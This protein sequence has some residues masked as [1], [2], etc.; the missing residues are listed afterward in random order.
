MVYGVAGPI[1]GFFYFCIKNCFTKLTTPTSRASHDTE[2][3]TACFIKN[4]QGKRVAPLGEVGGFDLTELTQ[5]NMRSLLSRLYTDYH[6]T[7]LINHFN[8][9]QNPH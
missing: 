7:Y 4:R 3:A 5:L 6:V 9:H 2:L 1:K 8:I